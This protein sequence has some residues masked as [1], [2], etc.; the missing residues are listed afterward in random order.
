MLNIRLSP[1]ATIPVKA[2]RVLANHYPKL[3]LY[4]HYGVAE[5]GNVYQSDWYCISTESGLAVSKYN[6]RRLYETVRNVIERIDYFGEEKAAVL[7]AEKVE[8][9]E[10]MV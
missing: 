5:N 4:A 1:E 8:R 6:Y 10:R 7:N 9:F 2:H 3:K